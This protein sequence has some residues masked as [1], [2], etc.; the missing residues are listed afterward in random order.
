MLLKFVQ[1]PQL[2]LVWKLNSKDALGTFIFKLALG[3]HIFQFGFFFG[4]AMSSKIL[5]SKLFYFRIL[6]E[7]FFAS[8]FV[9]EMERKR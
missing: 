5:G 1:A 6:F 2:L 4:K 3:N 8:K 7:Q 9:R